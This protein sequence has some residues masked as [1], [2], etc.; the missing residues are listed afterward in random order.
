VRFWQRAEAQGEE[1]EE[2]PPP[3]PPSSRL[4]EEAARLSAEVQAALTAR[5]AERDTVR[6]AQ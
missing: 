6:G 1:E 3:P 4:A 2:H 5:A